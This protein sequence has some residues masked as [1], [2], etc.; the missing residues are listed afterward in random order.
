MF[1]TQAHLHIFSTSISGFQRHYSSPLDPFSLPLRPPPGSLSSTIYPRWSQWTSPPPYA[2]STSCKRAQ[3]K[4][5]YHHIIY[6]LQRFVVPD[7]LEPYANID[8]GRP[9][10]ATSW[11]NMLNLKAMDA[12]Q[13][14]QHGH[15]MI[16]FIVDYYKTIESFP[17]LSHVE[18]GYLR[19]TL[20]DSAPTRGKQLMFIAGWSSHTGMKSKDEE[21]D[22]H[23]QDIQVKVIP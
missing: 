21:V 3:N 9:Q 7:S 4:P 2:S 23:Q 12:E 1:K 10:L 16:A 13:L 22:F 5:K 15:K 17:V 18:P 20:P 6:L 19:K 14:R 8:K 11:E